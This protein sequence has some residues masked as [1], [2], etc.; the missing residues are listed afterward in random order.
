MEQYWGKI[1]ITNDEK[2]NPF[3][4]VIFAE[5][6]VKSM[7]KTGMVGEVVAV[8]VREETIS[9]NLCADITVVDDG[10][11]EHKHRYMSPVGRNYK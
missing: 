9:K 1:K 6:S 11:V 2:V 8:E 3:V 5:D 7:Q 10:G 4:A